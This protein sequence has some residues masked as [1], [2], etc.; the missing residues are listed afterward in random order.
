MNELII[1]IGENEWFS[2]QTDECV[3]DKALDRFLETAENVG[4]NLDN[5]HIVKAELR[6]E[7]GETISVFSNP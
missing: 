2:F 5:T 7:D 6:N 3:A 4:I 1:V